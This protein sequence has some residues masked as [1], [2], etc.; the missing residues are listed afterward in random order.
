M[1]NIK[2]FIC[3]RVYKIVMLRHLLLLDVKYMQKLE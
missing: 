1:Q 3:Y 2:H